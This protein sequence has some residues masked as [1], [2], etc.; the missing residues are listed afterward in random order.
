MRPALAKLAL[1]DRL[2]RVAVAVQ[3]PR[4]SPFSC[5]VILL[6]VVF[7]AM[8][9][10]TVGNNFNQVWEE[11][12]LVKLQ[13]LTRQLLS[14]NNLSPD[15]CLVAFQQYVRSRQTHERASRR[16]CPPNPPCSGQR[17]WLCLSP[18]GA[19]RS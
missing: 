12:Q 17:L 8:P 6:G 5:I 1:C 14:E 4:A 11:R 2:E 19:W 9:L 18:R 10:N 15:D 7:L 3:R 13:A 16:L